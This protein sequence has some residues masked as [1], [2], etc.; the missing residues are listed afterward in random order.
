MKTANDTNMRFFQYSEFDSPIE[1]GSGARMKKGTLS[2]LVKAREAYASP[3]R[4]TSGFRT[5]ADYIRLKEKGYQVARNS[6]HFKGYA[7]DLLDVRGMTT[8]R[9]LRLCDCMWAAGFR[10][11]GIMASALHVDDD[12]AKPTPAIWNYANTPK[13]LWESMQKW[14]NDKIKPDAS[15]N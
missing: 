8:E 13:P 2:K 1:K 3:L 12:P 10:R 14:Y 15:A 6:S 5:Q 11:F 9:F 4:V 7:V